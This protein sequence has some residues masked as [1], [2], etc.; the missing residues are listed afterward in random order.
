MCLPYVKKTVYTECVFLRQ[1]YF[2]DTFVLLVQPTIQRTER[3]LKLK[4]DQVEKMN[5]NYIHY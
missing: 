4:I 2:L 3:K 1:I 5:G